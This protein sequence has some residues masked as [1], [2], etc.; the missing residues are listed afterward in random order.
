MQLQLHFI[1]EETET[2]R[3]VY[4]RDTT[5]KC[6]AGFYPRLATLLTPMFLDNL[7]REIYSWEQPELDLQWLRQLDVESS[8]LS[9]NPSSSMSWQYDL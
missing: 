6:K 8:K 4:P 5:S 2:E 9:S 1:D 3:F 7:T